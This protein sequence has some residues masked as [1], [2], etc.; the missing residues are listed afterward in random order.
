MTRRPAA[1]I[2]AS[3]A[4]RFVGVASRVGVVFAAVLAVV[5]AASG[6]S[7]DLTSRPSVPGRR[8]QPEHDSAAVR[9]DR[10]RVVSR[11]GSA[12]PAP[13][14]ELTDSGDAAFSLASLRGAPAFVFFG[15]THCPDVCPATIGTVGLAMEAFGPGRPGRL[16]QRR[17]GA[18]HDRPG[19]AS[20]R[21]S[22]RGA[23]TALTGTS[24]QIRT[25]AD[26]WGVRYARVE[27]GVAGAYSMS[28]T[29]DVFLVDGAGSLRARFP[30]GTSSEAMTAV[31]RLVAGDTDRGLPDRH[32]RDDLDGG[33]VVAP[34]RARRQRP[35]SPR[36]RSA[37]TSSPRR[38]GPAP[39]GPVILPSV[40]GRCP[41]R[42]PDRHGRPSS[43]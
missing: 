36:W 39:A 14:I 31:L 17:S 37:W 19:C 5:V 11:P 23:F 2:G 24:A 32:A 35:H 20:T 28:H 18:R 41:H 10:R 15:Y 30:F 27:T 1:P 43:S 40:R 9:T 12:R 7:G 22:C 25:T 33:T 16:R 3:R 21:G 13:P 26:A 4:T 42:R 6:L 8:R 38:S 34:C 29:A